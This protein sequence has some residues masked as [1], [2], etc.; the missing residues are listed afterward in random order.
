MCTV[1][2]QRWYLFEVIHF[3]RQL[4]QCEQNELQQRGVV[5]GF[6]VGEPGVKQPVATNSDKPEW[7]R[8]HIN[9]KRGLHRDSKGSLDDAN[10]ALFIH[11]FIYLV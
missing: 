10:Y 8:E 5:G 11:I 6:G 4:L 9:T 7:R 2:K 1:E 3:E